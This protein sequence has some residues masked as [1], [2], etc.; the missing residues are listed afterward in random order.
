MSQEQPVDLQILNKVRHLIPE[1]FKIERQ[2]KWEVLKR[3][4]LVQR[5]LLKSSNRFKLEQ[6]AKYDEF[7]DALDQA[8]YGNNMDVIKQFENFKESI[9]PKIKAG[10]QFGTINGVESL[11]LNTFE[12]KKGS[13]KTKQGSTDLIVFWSSENEKSTRS[14]NE[15]NNWLSLNQNLKLQIN[16]IAVSLDDDAN[17]FKNHL[18]NNQLT[19]FQHYR[20]SLGWD[21]SNAFQRAMEL[22]YLPKI[23]VVGKEN[24]VI[25]VTRKAR[26]VENIIKTYWEAGS[27]SEDDGK[28]RELLDQQTFRFI[29]KALT[30]Q[31][32]DLLSQNKS[33][34]K[35]DFIRL[36]LTKCYKIAQDGSKEIVERSHLKVSYEVS[37]QSTQ[38]IK[39]FL[40]NVTAVLGKDN[41]QVKRSIVKDPTGML[42]MIT[43]GFQDVLKKNYKVIQEYTIRSEYFNYVH[44]KEEFQPDVK[45]VSKKAIQNLTF[46]EYQTIYTQVLPIFKKYQQEI[47]DSDDDSDNDEE[48]EEDK[49]LI[50]DRVNELTDCLKSGLELS[51]GQPFQTIQNYHPFGKDQVVDIEHK[52]DQV[53]IVMYWDDNQQCNRQFTQILK[54]LL[55]NEE[56]FKDKVRLVAL[57]KHK[58]E[59]YELFL[60]KNQGIEEVVEFYFPRDENQADQVQYNVKS[61]PHFIVVDKV[62]SIRIQSQVED[63]E[64]VITSYIEESIESLNQKGPLNDDEY[65]EITQFLYSDAR[66]KLSQLSNKR[67]FSLSFI[68][69]EI[70]QGEKVVRFAPIIEYTI[71][72]GKQKYL[73]AFLA[74]LNKVVPLSN[75]QV[76]QTVQRTLNLLFPG[77]AC[78]LCQNELND[79]TQ[80]YYSPFSDEFYCVK[81]AE[82]VDPKAA[83][84]KKFRVQ[85]NLIFFNAPLVDKSVLNDIDV[86]RVGNNQKVKRGDQYTQNHALD[87]NGCDGDVKGFR[88]I[89]LNCLPGKLTDLAL[90]D[91]CQDCFNEIRTGGPRLEKIV[92][93]TK[94]YGYNPSMLMLRVPFYM[95]YYDY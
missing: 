20:Y 27:E 47:D 43:S 3:K 56:K 76:N 91:F 64:S 30:Q 75:F 16:P 17:N 78:K 32:A 89:V 79:Q 33:F 8:T 69:K 39:L 92:K 24:E 45:V 87:C 41:V 57:S 14:L 44:D 26:E 83:G 37:V 59:A 85:D 49:R 28:Y 74:L 86:Y 9:K 7:C 1:S 72:E 93:R 5:I 35:S 82:V 31:I 66:K 12:T 84:Y 19:Q 53:L 46:K 61:F 48:Q 36:S 70:D 29:K 65:S 15:L 52:D 10:F 63:I 2:K 38:A 13:F 6:T 51:L 42:D 67:Q 90:V 73:D 71:R 55:V 25:E 23:A 21:S 81:C 54:V 34:A 80:Q 95:G 62:G 77:K 50:F 11:D 22:N 4:G 94:I 68:F 18:K 40:N 88:Y 58:Q 60:L